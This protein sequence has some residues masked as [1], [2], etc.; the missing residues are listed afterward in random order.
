MIQKERE[1]EYIK[2]FT[3]LVQQPESADVFNAA[4]DQIMGACIPKEELDVRYETFVGNTH[5]DSLNSQMNE[6]MSMLYS[7][8]KN[9]ED[10]DN[11]KLAQWALT[12]FFDDQDL[13]HDDI[14]GIGLVDDMTVVDYALKVLQK[15]C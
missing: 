6:K 4:M 13:I 8:M 12:Y 14:S 2:A 3:Q 15:E 1:E 10:P 5:D 9:D 11:R 7:V